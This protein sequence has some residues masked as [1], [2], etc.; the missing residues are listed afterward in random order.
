MRAGDVVVAQTEKDTTLGSQSEQLRPGGGSLRLPGFKVL[1]GSARAYLRR[2]VINVLSRDAPAPDYDFPKGDPGLFGPDTVT[3]KIH[4]DFPSMMAG[5]LGALMLQSLHPLALAGVWDHSDFRGD[6]LGRLRG[7]IAFVAR[8]TY[9]PRATA[10][11]AIERVRAIHREVHGTAADG[12]AYSAEDPHLLNWVHCAEAWSFLEGY[13]TYCRRDIP[14]DMQDQYLKETARVAEALGARDVPTSLGKLEE[15]FNS[16][17][18]ELAYDERT[19]TVLG[20]LGAIRLPI[21][22]SGLGRGM[23]LG[24]GA[25]LLPDWARD[26]MDKSLWEKMR[27]PAASR[28]L[29]LIAPSIRDAMAEGGLAWRA[30]ARTGADYENLFRWTDGR[31]GRIR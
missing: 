29:K 23:F 2:W 12:R 20:A 22:M 6:M 27:D 4:A 28:A 19:R 18:A 1:P 25:A 31:P 3:W 9:A 26:L 10:E 5:G 7:T 21:P 30:C 8:T 14:R 13:K 24:A 11:Q 16:V 15:Y 17:R